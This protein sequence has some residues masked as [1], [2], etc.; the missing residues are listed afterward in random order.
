MSLQLSVR[1]LLVLLLCVGLCLAAFS[2]HHLLGSLM[3][4]ILAGILAQTAFVRGVYAQSPL[5]PVVVRLLAMAFAIAASILAYDSW[6]QNGGWLSIPLDIPYWI[7]A[8][9]HVMVVSFA[10]HRIERPAGFALC[11]LSSFLLLAGF[12][13]QYNFGDVTGHVTVLRWTD[14]S[15]VQH[16]VEILYSPIETLG[17]REGGMIIP[18]LLWFTPTLTTWIV[19]VVL[20][21]RCER[22]AQ[23]RLEQER[24]KWVGVGKHLPTYS[25]NSDDKSSAWG[26]FNVPNYH[27]PLTFPH[28]ALRTRPAP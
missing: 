18:N 13:L 8:L 17:L 6:L 2:H 5:Q 7:G 12:A 20:S 11:Y 1:S 4:A 27:S 21:A 9:L 28:P 19:L 24:A 22:N 3:L 10:A 14:S 25:Q 15:T 26:E 23:R 16:L